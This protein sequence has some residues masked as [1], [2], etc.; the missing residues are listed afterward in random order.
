M[1][2]LELIDSLEDLLVHARR[3]PGGNLV[4][5]RKRLLDVVDQLRLSV[6]GDVRQATQ[7][8]EAREQVIEDAHRQSRQ[9]LADA[10]TERA[11]RLDENSIVREAQE[12]SHGM[13]MDAET[14]ARQVIAEADATAAAHLSEAAEASA[15]Q[16][17]DA[18]EYA[19]E[20]LRRLENQLHGF[21]ESIRAG[22]SSLQE[23]R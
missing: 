23:R 6:P 10:E 11:R 22:I 13:L 19:L 16:L 4:I 12:R 1:E 21:L 7:V 5:D 9:L 3:L 18:D 20:V 15:R 17:D 14:R 2:I 8:L